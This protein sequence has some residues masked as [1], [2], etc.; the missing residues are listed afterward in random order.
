MIE[1]PTSK[2]ARAADGWRVGFWVVAALGIPAAAVAWAW[3]GLAQFEAQTEQG[4][5]VSAGTTMAGFAEMVGGVPLVLAHLL[6]LIG[7]I[8]LG[9]KGY[10]NSGIVFSVTAVLIASGVGIGVA[11]LLWAGE[12]FQ[13]GITNNTYVP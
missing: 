3:Y 9:Y 8:V 5:A 6:G 1:Q 13:L 11:Q 12:L 4:K 2:Q 7:L 10:G